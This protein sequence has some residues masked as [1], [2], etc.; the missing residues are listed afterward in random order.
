MQRSRS[1]SSSPNHG[2]SCRTIKT[3][4]RPRQSLEHK[5]VRDPCSRNR[6]EHAHRVCK[7]GLL[8]RPPRYAQK[9]VVC[10]RR[11]GAVLAASPRYV[12]TRCRTAQIER[13]LAVVYTLVVGGLA[14]EPLLAGAGRSRLELPRFTFLARGFAR[15]G[16]PGLRNRP[17]S[18]FGQG[19][20]II[21]DSTGMSCQLPRS[22]QHCNDDEQHGNPWNAS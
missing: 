19:C 17:S 5:V 1:G 21:E 22:L 9:V 11:L 15:W 6:L 3:S 13:N 14:A 12:R 2:A 4:A 20:N 18:L 7:V 10:Y 16:R 8:D